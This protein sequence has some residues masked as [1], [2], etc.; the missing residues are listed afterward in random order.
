MTKKKTFSA[1]LPQLRKKPAGNPLW[2]KGHNHPGPGRP[3]GSKD[4]YTRE[5]KQ[6]LLDAIEHVGE[7]IADAKEVERAKQGLEPNLCLR[8]I[9][10]YLEWVAQEY[11]AV[12]SAMLSR[13]M[14]QQTESSHEV[15]HTYHT[16][17]EIAN[18]LKQLG[19]EPKRIYDTYPLIET[20]KQ[21][22]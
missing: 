7:M 16:M 6:A 15:K 8:G 2:T 11:P 12:A 22:N 5:I 18:R 9:A 3:K 19:L 1:R 13:M 10:S 17:E 20:K 21:L 4:K 14:P